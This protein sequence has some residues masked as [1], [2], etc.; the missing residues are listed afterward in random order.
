VML[1]TVHEYAGEKLEESGELEELRRRHARYFLALAEEAEPELKGP[2]QYEWVKRLEAE[3][4]NMR[5]A[6]SWLLEG[7]EIELGLRLA[8]ALRRF[9]H[10]RG[11][12]DEGRRWLEQA[13]AKDSRASVSSR[14]KALDA[15]GGLAHDQGDVA[16]AKS[17]AQEGLELGA[18]ADTESGRVASFKRTLGITAE[19]EGDYE[20]ATELYEKSLALYR[21]TEDKWSI[22]TSLISLG[23]VWV[24]REEHELAKELY[25]EALVLSRESGDPE[26]YA[27][28]LTNLGYEHLLEGD[29]EQATALNEEAA[30][31]YRDRGS[32]GGLVYALDNL[33]WAAL[34]RG[35][36]G[37]ARVLHEE[38]LALCRELG[39]KLIGSESLE[40]LACAAAARGEAERSARLFGA[41]ATLGYQQAPAERALRE[42]YLA[43]ARSLLEEAAWKTAWSEGQAMT[44]EEAVSYALEEEADS[45]TTDSSEVWRKE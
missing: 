10:V 43:E 7:G 19:R 20:R 26:Q 33:A 30:R 35:D 22:T 24:A 5:A 44:F 4:D 17:A 41:A 27:T 12:F 1:E 31:L 40:G 28:G 34:V 29:H 23:N 6:L 45:D 16:R 13:L 9:W 3:H 25:R 37:R 39:D 18:R 14:A 11:Y 38:T 8:G 2:R 42:P 21:E 32:R 15:V 36:H